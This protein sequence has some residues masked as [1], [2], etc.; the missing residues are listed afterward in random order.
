MNDIA[1]LIKRSYDTASNTRKDTCRQVFCKRKSIGQTE[2]YQSNAT[3]YRPELKLILA[4]YMDY[5]GETLA[6]F[7]GQRYRIIKTYRSGRTMELTLESASKEEC[8]DYEK[9]N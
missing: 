5:N 6:D 8:D 4:D 2:F 3:E 1:V 7:E 9:D